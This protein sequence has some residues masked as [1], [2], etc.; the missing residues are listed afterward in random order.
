MRQE[1]CPL[2]F[3]NSLTTYSITEG[4]NRS[5]RSIA[6]AP[7]KPFIDLTVP[8]VPVVPSLARFQPFR[9]V[10]TFILSGYLRQWTSKF[11]DC[12]S[13][14]CFLIHTR[15]TVDAHLETLKFSLEIDYATDFAIIA[16]HVADKRTNNPDAKTSRNATFLDGTSLAQYTYQQRSNPGRRT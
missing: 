12:H 9:I 15:A 16:I 14:W 13:A 3:S 1:L 11:P 2:L 4:S 5:R 8:I 7:F 10:S 6:C